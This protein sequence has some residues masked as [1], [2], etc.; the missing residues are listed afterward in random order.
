MRVYAPVPYNAR[1]ANKYTTLPC[2]GG[3]DGSSRVV[4]RKGDKVL[5][6][7][8]AAHRSIKT[9]NEDALEFIQRDGEILEMK[10]RA[11]FYSI[12]GQGFAPVV[13][14]NPFKK[15]IY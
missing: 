11:T 12:A 14:A 8:W 9:L 7:T 6:S 5:F 13:S 3:A 4:V 10:H 2:G 1:T 15:D